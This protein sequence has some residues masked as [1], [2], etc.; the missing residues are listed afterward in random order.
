ML[1]H[2]IEYILERPPIFTA[3]C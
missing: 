2:K 1:V 3:Q